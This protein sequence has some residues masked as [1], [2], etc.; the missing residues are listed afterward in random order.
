[1]ST[2]TRLNRS[3]PKAESHRKIRYDPWTT[4]SPAFAEDIWTKNIQGLWKDSQIEPL[5]RI[6][7][8][9]HSQGQKIGLQIAHAGRKVSIREVPPC[10]LPPRFFPCLIS[11]FPKASTVAPWLASGDLAGTA[12]GGWPDKV[13]G[14]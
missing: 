10:V 7:E 11:V 9:A 2:D 12:V 8:F 6:V 13:I 5:R 1:M 3:R 4:P 14:R